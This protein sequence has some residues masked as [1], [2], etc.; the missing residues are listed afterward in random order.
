MP[1]AASS[2]TSWDT[3]RT[4]TAAWATGSTAHA[5]AGPAYAQ[6]PV[7]DAPLLE[8]GAASFARWFA[9]RF[10]RLSF[11]YSRRCEYEADAYGAAVVGARR[12]W[13][14]R[15]L[16]SR[17]S[18]PAGARQAMLDETLPQLIAERER[19]T[20][21]WLALVQQA[22][23]RQPPQADRVASA[24]RTGI[25]AGRHPS[26]AGRAG[27]CA[28]RERR[29]AAGGGHAA[30]AAG[31]CGVVGRLAGGRRAPRRCGLARVAR[32]PVAAAACCAASTSAA[33]SRS[34]ARPTT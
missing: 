24:A 13:R 23:H 4:A 19:P 10:S 2:R 8:R 16:R 21:A 27:R 30:G 26:V 12:R 31:R 25:G 11:A 1:C 5:P 33:G 29:G 9:P 20:A 32:G 6:T 14:R 18:T 22:V 28:R 34:C 15:C 3:S 7:E 17:L